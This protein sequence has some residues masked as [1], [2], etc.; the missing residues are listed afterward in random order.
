MVGWVRRMNIRV[1]LLL[2]AAA[3]ALLASASSA[4]A[5][6][7]FLT[8]GRTLSIK[9]HRIDGDVMILGLRGG[10]QVTCDKTLISK[11]EADEVPYA[12]PAAPAQAPAAEAEALQGSS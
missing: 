3:F 8:S 6:I 5:E 4:S 10:G 2:S 9:D 7:V 1:P 11:I 12:E